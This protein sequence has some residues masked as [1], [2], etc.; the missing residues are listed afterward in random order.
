MLW[1]ISLMFTLLT[2]VALFITF[3]PFIYL[4]IIATLEFGMVSVYLAG[5]RGKEIGSGMLFGGFNDFKRVAGGMLWMWFWLLIWFIIP[6]AG[7]VFVVIKGFA[8]MF[9][10]Y[11]LLTQPDI[12]ATQALKRSVEM[13]QGYKGKMFGAYI[14]I[15]AIVVVAFIILYLL[16]LIPYLGIVFKVI[17]YIFSIACIA[18]LP[19]FEGLV[20]AAFYDEI[21]RVRK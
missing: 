11:I 21:E 19:L 14:L 5:Y 18:F 4:P 1:G 7:I 3:I 10:P 6:L 12:S 17:Y 2:V 15:F 13:T 8:Y 16:G 20:G 9:V